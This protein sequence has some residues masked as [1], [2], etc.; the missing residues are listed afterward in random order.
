L[1][2]GLSDGLRL[3]GRHRASCC[4]GFLRPF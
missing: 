4:D 3:M 1:L 2:F